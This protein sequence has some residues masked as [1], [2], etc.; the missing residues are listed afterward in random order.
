MTEEESLFREALAKPPSERSTFLDQACAGQPELRA[1]T[2]ALL[3]A[4]EATGTFL[5]TPAPRSTGDYAPAAGDDVPPTVSRPS[6]T[7]SSPTSA[8]GAV[9][10][11]RYTLVEK[12]G[13]GGMGEVWVARQTEPVKRNVA[14]KLIK[15]GLDSRAVLQR[16][17]QER[18]ALALMDHPNIAR[19]LD[20]GMTADRRPFFV[21]ELVDGRA[22][23]KFCDEAKLG[24][25]ERLDLFV[26]ICQA[27]QHAHQKGIVH[28]DLKPSNI[29]VTLIDGRPIPKVIDF[30]MAKATGDQLTDEALSTQYGAVVGT[31]DYMAPEQAGSGGQDIDTRADVYSLGVILY[32]LLTGLRPIEGSRL[33]K[34]PLSDVVRIIQEEEPPRP[35][36]R[37][38]TD[39][40]L[41]SLATRRRIEPP[42][43]KALLRADLDWVVMK[44]LEKQRDRRYA[45]ANA[46][47]RD[48]ERYLA[49]AAV[50]ACPPSVGYRLGKF[51][52]RNRGSVIAVSLLLLAL[53]GGII[54]TTWGLVNA[55]AAH[56]AEAEQR[57]VAE[58]E[59]KKAEQA[60][61]AAR[62][63]RR[64]AESREAQAIAAVKRFRDAV[65]NEPELKNSKA[66]DRLR[67]RLLKEPL[68]FF[69]ELRDRLQ[70]D[71]DTRLES[72]VRLAQAS[73]DLAQLT[74]EI[75]DRQDALTA[76]RETLAIY[77][78]LADANPADTFFQ[79]SLASCHVNIGILLLETGKPAE[80]LAA[81]ESALAINRR[82]ADGNPTVA[83]VQQSLASTYGNIGHLL[84]R[85][86]NLPQALQATES[87][88]AIY[89]KLVDARPDVAEYQSQ[90]ARCQTNVGAFLGA[91]GNPAGA[92]KAYESAR[93]VLQKLADAHPTV[94]DYQGYLAATHH[95]IGQLWAAQNP[96]EALKAYEPALA[97][98]RKLADAHPSVTDFQSYLATCHNSIGIVLSRIG[99]RAEALKAYEAALATRQR[100]ADAHPTVTDFQNYLANSHDSIGIFLKATGKPAEARK[101]HEAGLAIRH[102]LA[103]EHPESPD[104]ASSL[105]GT[106]TNLAAVDLAAKRY[107]EAR[108]GLQQAVVWQRKALAVNPA[109]PRYR[110][111]MTNHL[112]G[113][114]FVARRLGDAEGLAEAERELAT[115]RESD[116]ALRALDARLAAIIRGEQKPADQAERL[117]LAQRAHAR[118]LHAT[119]ARLWGEALAK[120]P[121]LGDD[122]TNQYRYRAACAAALAGCGKGKDD[123]APNDEARSALRRQALDWLRAELTVWTRLL[124]NADERQRAAIAQVLRHWCKDPDLAGIRGDDALAR[125]TE[126]ERAACKRLW[127][128]VDGLLTQV[129][130]P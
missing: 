49:G 81:Y 58:S 129:S 18:Q 72:L 63:Q 41:P 122:R 124:A 52:R 117:Q 114:A 62:Q 43:L 100:L 28:R 106:L 82:L 99:K 36:T 128:D 40:E 44:C 89:R 67:R 105:G 70:A 55:D 96:V 53:V 13:E 16:F 57:Q 54:G 110:Q 33:R 12:L 116:P 48:I 68:A 97:I 90:L 95:N 50:E 15:A 74:N 119:A 93:A 73:F 22:L 7:A 113:L 34:A 21:M 125:L 102:K 84:S 130:K 121:Q 104:F 17:E 23:G 77:R 112:I 94:A 103:R 126:R 14:L 91:T 120:H 24:I 47:A 2:E 51:L 61:E 31:L 109:H 25:R 78:K 37:L 32:E 86:G 123:P 39:P 71:R 5:D 59:K 98:Y 45:T 11:G 1:A 6:S 30:G 9:I 60:A 75:G 80:A 65:A 64:R 111:Y 115:F 101:A 42:K 76:Y 83:D 4:H 118:A 38:A 88:L 46:L 108:A 35:S 107:Q 87:A 29:L 19:V 3:A 8:P 27:V 69:R 10:A 85:T 56:R 66:L 92:L 20:G 26:P 127:N 79:Q